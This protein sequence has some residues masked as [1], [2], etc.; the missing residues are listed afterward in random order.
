MKWWQHLKQG[1]IENV[2]LQSPIFD[3]LNCPRSNLAIQEMI[4]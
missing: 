1:I 3:L 2:L 4:I